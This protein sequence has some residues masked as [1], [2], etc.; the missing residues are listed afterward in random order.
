MPLGQQPARLDTEFPAFSPAQLNVPEGVG[1][2]PPVSSAF[3]RTL[4]RTSDIISVGALLIA[5]LPFMLGFALAIRATGSSPLF[6]HSRIGKHGRS[7]QCYKFR[8]MVMDADS[9]LSAHLANN[10]E[11]REEWSR[12]QKLRN[13]PRVTRIGRFLRST[14]L[15]ELPQLINVLRGEMTLV[16]PR[17]VVH[18]ELERY[19]TGLRDYLSVRPGLTGLWQ[20]SGR[21]DTGYDERVALDVWYVRHRSLWLDLKILLKTLAVPFRRQGAY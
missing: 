8:T 1:A 21:N 15:D 3:Y 12:D 18:E 11:A 9:V 4:K 5:L 2:L 14:S 7:F 20:V 13:D 19:G 16:G 17:P 10:L 6:S